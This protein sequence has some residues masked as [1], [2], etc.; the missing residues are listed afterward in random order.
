MINPLSTLAFDAAWLL[1]ALPLALLPLWRRSSAAL[2]NTWLVL[3]GGLQPD[4]PSRCLWATLQATE[5]LVLA[6]LIVAAAGPHRPEHTVQRLGQGA[7]IVLVLDRSRSMDQGFSRSR[8]PAGLRGTGPQALDYYM[9]QTPGRLR[10][11]KGQAARALLADFT[12]RRPD[13]RFALVVFSTLPIRVLGFTSHNPVVQAAIAANDIGRGLSETQIGSAL[14]LA[15]DQFEGRPYNGSRSVMLVSDGGDRLD[16]D[17]RTR[18]ARRLVQLRVAVYWLYLRAA[19]SPG[20]SV[21][22]GDSAAAAD[23]VP[24][25]LLHNWFRSLPT[26]YRAYEASDAEALAQ[27]MHDVDQR[28]QLPISQQDLLPRQDLT[29]ALQAVALAGLL[30]LWLAGRLEI[31][32]WQ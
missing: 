31:K 11:S 3:Q 4:R 7:E 15:L 9:S 14:D 22:E 28:E 19:N 24:E 32:R 27:A 29:P 23:S 10:E 8:P 26:P 16:P 13:D 1:W 5:V 17:A 12:A 30:L 25:M 20:L 6:T 2:N 18:L 21:A